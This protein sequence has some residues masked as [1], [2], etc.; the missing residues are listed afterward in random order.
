MLT[1]K[2][3]LITGAGGSFGTCFINRLL[4]DHDIDKVICFS[5]DP[6]KH[7]VLRQ[8][9]DNHPK[10]NCII[11]DVRDKDRLRIAFDGVDYVIH[12]A[13]L[14]QVVDGEYNADEYV[15]TNVVGTGNVCYA[16]WAAG[17]RKVVALSSDK[18][19]SPCNNYGR[20][21]AQ[22][23]G[24]AINWNHYA[25]LSD[26]RYCA[27]RYG[28]VIGS[29][30]SVVPFFRKMLAAGEPLQITDTRMTRFWMS[31]EQSVD[32]VLFALENMIGG[33]TFVPSLPAIRIMDLAAAMVH[34]KVGD[35]LDE[36]PPP[37]DESVNVAGC[38]FDIIGIREGEKLH[39][40]LIAP[41]EVGRTQEYGGYYIIEP[42]VSKWRRDGEGWDA[43]RVDEDFSYTSDTAE[44]LSV[45]QI[46][47]SIDGS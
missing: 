27:T 36:M 20:S 7:D 18:A 41:E 3:I 32:L 47:E 22:A 35:G 46:R 45:E 4:N 12:A 23:E 14:K 24:V 11:G 34:D 13:A 25:A 44:F 42:M 15:K 10:L 6:H 29:E 16:A 30:G 2:R 28:N 1:D 17:V 8:R 31:L 26:T 19:C 5:R 43:E 40:A 38:F 39:E 21:K 33:E 37:P 9:F